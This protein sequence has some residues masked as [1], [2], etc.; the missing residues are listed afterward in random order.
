M[1]CSEKLAFYPYFAILFESDRQCIRSSYSYQVKFD[2]V[3]AFDSPC[4]SRNLWIITSTTEF[5]PVNNKICNFDVKGNL[6]QP[7]RRNQLF[8]LAERQATCRVQNQSF[9]EGLFKSLYVR[10]LRCTFTHCCQNIRW[11]GRHLFCLEKNAILYFAY[12]HQCSIKQTLW[13]AARHWKLIC[14]K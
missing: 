12:C 3:T 2:F 11:T 6:Q 5:Q 9:D 7:V 13:F 14:S 4:R 1:H 8:R 10:C